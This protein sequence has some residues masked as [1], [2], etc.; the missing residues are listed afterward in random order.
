MAVKKVFVLAGEASGDILGA[1]FLS[2]WRAKFPTSSI[3]YTGGPA[4]QAVLK[5]QSP[6]VAMDRMAFMGFAEVLRH[7]PAIW[8]NDRRIKA[9][10]R[11][12]RPD[13]IVLVD[14]PGYN[15]RLAKWLDAQGFRHAGTR[16]V[17]LV[18]PQF[19]AWKAGRLA[20][21]QSHL[22][23]VYPLLPFEAKLLAEAGV[24]APYAGHPAAHRVTMGGWDP[25]GPLALLPGSRSQ[26][27]AQ[28]VRVFEETAR[29]L[30]RE[31]HW[32]R[33]AHISAPDYQAMLQGFGV[34]VEEQQIKT[35]VPTMTGYAAALVASGTAT[36]EVALRGIPMVVAYK[37][38]ALSYAIGKRVIRVPYISLVN[39]IL[40]RAAVAECIQARCHPSVLAPALY[41]ALA[42]AHWPQTV[43]DLRHAIDHGN[44]MPNLVLHAS[45]L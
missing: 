6:V 3:T 37:T 32:F 23:A 26:E 24:E 13:L 7:L 9:H 10:L 31:A 15:L 5:G 35:G 36:L 38:S 12:K 28:H 30:Q 4:M 45:Q 29:A 43:R 44:P 34:E 19:W 16:V 11:A 2:A 33:P 42:D 1:E 27:F 41:S 14:Y 20:L 40:D 18:C 39:L 25:Q 17:Q 21:L 8:A 22:D